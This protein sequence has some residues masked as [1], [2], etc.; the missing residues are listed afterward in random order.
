VAPDTNILISLR[1]ELSEVEGGAGLVIGPLWS[2][3]DRPVD[4]LRDL[5]QLWWWRDV[6][7]CV[8]D[9]Y[10]GD[11]RKKKP[12]SPERLRARRAAV[13]ELEQDFAERGGYET[14]VREGVPVE[15]RPCAL[16]SIPS[17]R[18]P[19]R[20]G[21]AGE[22]RWPREELDRRLLSE[23]F[24]GGCHVFVTADK[25]ILRCH[26][27]FIGDGLA[28]LSPAAL[29]DELDDSG[30]LDDC[31]SAFTSPSPDITALG[32]LYGGFAADEG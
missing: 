5:V 6:R 7:F 28:I 16:H 1:Q 13:R 8:S 14:F 32:R 29:L 19:G 31:D 30:E 26:D 15:D 12:L 9:L 18:L 4:A 17:C 10:L 2:D 20:R 22:R 3:R 25:G 23:A 11:A 27:S 21:S 24:D